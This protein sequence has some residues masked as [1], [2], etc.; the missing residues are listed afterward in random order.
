[1]FTI[2]EKSYATLALIYFT[3]AFTGLSAQTNSLQSTQINIAEF[4][5]QTAV[6]AIGGLFM[7]AHARCLLTHLHQSKWALALAMLAAISA[8]WSCDPLFSLRRGLV[9]FATTLWGAYFGCR[10]NREEQIELLCHA[11]AIVATLSLLTAILFPA[12][13]IDHAVHNGDWRGIFAEKN[14]LGRAMVLGLI[15]LIAK[16]RGS[17]LSAC[18]RGASLVLCGLLVLMSHSITAILMSAV[19]LACSILYGLL[20]LP[21]KWLVPAIATLMCSAVLALPFLDSISRLTLLLG[22]D[23]TMTGRT[24]IWRAALSA[25]ALRP[26]LGY[27]FNAFWHDMN[28]P[29]ASILTQVRWLTPHAHNGYLDLMLDLGAVGVTLFLAGIV[30][31]LRSAIREYRILGGRAALWPLLYLTFLLLYNMTESTGFKVNSVFWVLYTAMQVRDVLI[32][33][34]HFAPAMWSRTSEQE[35]PCTV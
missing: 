10:F 22:R 15:A 21:A 13:G 32:A 33:E 17:W 26:V 7:V 19:L 12:I 2:L 24:Q 6:Y 20:R 18:S 3:S 30:L 34:P 14:V 9:I 35:A 16:P 28:G 4:A 23:L 11:M 27:G 1:M 8:A 25:I 5:L 29:S 31:R